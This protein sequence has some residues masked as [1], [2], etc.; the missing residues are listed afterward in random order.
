M[1]F[2]ESIKT[3]LSKYATFS[4]RARRSEYWWWWLF[5]TVAVIILSIVD[6]ALGLK[7]SDAEV[8]GQPATGFLSLIFALAVLVPGIAVTFRRLHDTGRSGW[9]WLL[10]LLCGIGAI[11]VFVMCLQD[12]KPDNEYGPNPKGQPAPA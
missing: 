10:S 7:V 5:V 3:V 12:S 6:G 2:G 1:S 11:I 8:M 4:G 9:W